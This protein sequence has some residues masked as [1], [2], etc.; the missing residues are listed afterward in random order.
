MPQQTHVPQDQVG[1][2]VQNYADGDLTEVEAKKQDDGT[3]TVTA[4]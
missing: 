2:V 4:R 1:R 3:W